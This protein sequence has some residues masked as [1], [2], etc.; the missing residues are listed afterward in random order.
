MKCTEVH[1]TKKVV[2]MTAVPIGFDRVCCGRSVVA[3]I[4]DLAVFLCFLH[5]FIDQEAL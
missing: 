5:S 2:T 4:A 1:G 3:A